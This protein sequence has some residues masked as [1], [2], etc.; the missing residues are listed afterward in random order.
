MTKAPATSRA[1]VRERTRGMRS[2]SRVGKYMPNHNACRITVPT[3]A[4]GVEGKRIFKKATIGIATPVKARTLRKKK[5]QRGQTVGGV[6]QTNAA[7]PPQPT[8][9]KNNVV[10]RKVKMEGVFG[11][12]IST[13]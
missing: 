1:I 2:H 8:M 4:G 11:R 10:G 5:S 7:K 12:C 13:S 9:I 6:Y 3:V